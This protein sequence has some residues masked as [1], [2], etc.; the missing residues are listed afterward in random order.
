MA[1]TSPTDA[2]GPSPTN[3]IL[4]I[5]R[6]ASGQVINGTA[7]DDFIYVWGGNN[8]L[9]GADGNDELNTMTSSFGN[10]LLGQNG[11]D[12]LLGV[13]HPGWLEHDKHGADRWPGQRQL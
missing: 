12:L 5:D 7:G 2:R 13:E 10:V 11:D 9:V 6:D 4:P 8:T 3:G 1:K